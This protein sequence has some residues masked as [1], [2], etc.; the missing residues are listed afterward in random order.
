MEVPEV[1]ISDWQEVHVNV[2][3][4]EAVSESQLAFNL[5]L[6]KRDKDTKLWVLQQ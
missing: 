3:V 6:V 2:T 4:V 1:L 5:K